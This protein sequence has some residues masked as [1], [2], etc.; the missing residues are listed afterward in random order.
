MI[1]AHESCPC[2]PS[3]SRFFFSVTVFIHLGRQFLVVCMFMICREACSPFIHMET[4]AQLQ[5]KGASPVYP[6][7]ILGRC[8]NFFHCKFVNSF[9]HFSS[10]NNASCDSCAPCPRLALRTWS[11]PWLRMGWTSPQPSIQRLRTFGTFGN[12]FR[13]FYFLFRVPS[14]SKQ[15]QRKMVR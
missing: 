8:F 12:E 7:D 13:S 1:F 6:A 14:D 4:W 15:D 3:F 5:M 9:L 11:S 2:D 10:Q